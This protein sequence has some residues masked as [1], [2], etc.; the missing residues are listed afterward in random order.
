[1]RQT[2]EQDLIAAQMQTGDDDYADGDFKDVGTSAC[3]ISDTFHFA[4]LF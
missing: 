1:M 3:Y 2:T 4:K